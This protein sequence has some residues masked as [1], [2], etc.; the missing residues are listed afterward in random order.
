MDEIE[1]ALDIKEPIPMD[2]K[3]KIPKL[4]PV[5][6]FNGRK[7]TKKLSS[8][9]A[10]GKVKKHFSP[11]VIVKGKPGGRRIAPQPSAKAKAR[12]GK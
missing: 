10:R 6:Q 2:G 9:R 7:P 4:P 1:N 12:K 3:P 5:V 11:G 8:K